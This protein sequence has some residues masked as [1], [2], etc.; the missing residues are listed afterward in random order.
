M[1]TFTNSVVQDVIR[2]ASHTFHILF[3]YFITLQQKLE[4]ERLK[5]AAMSQGSS[6]QTLTSV[7]TSN[8]QIKIEPEDGPTGPPVG[9]PPSMMDVIHL[10]DEDE[11]SRSSQ[12]LDG[13]NVSNQ[14]L[15]V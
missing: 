6:I 4:E 14:S 8:I 11:H 5:Q 3:T 7:G 15:W 10:K 2:F 9:V 13:S 12:E 1:L